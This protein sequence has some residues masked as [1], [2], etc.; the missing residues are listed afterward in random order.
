MILTDHVDTVTQLEYAIHVGHLFKHDTHGRV[1]H[2]DAEKSRQ[3]EHKC[4]VDTDNTVI[5]K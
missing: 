5:I 3:C 1:D 2:Q 4:N